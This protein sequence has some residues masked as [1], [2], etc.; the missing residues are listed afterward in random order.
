[1]RTVRA[2]Q[3]EPQAVGAAC[4]PLPAAPPATTRAVRADTGRANGPS[5]PSPTHG[6]RRARFYEGRSLHFVWLGRCAP[7]PGLHDK[8]GRSSAGSALP[9]QQRKQGRTRPVRTVRA[10][11]AEPQA[12]RAACAPRRG[13]N[14]RCAHSCGSSRPV[15]SA[16]GLSAGL[17]V[18]VPPAQHV[19]LPGAGHAAT[20]AERKRV[21]RHCSR[22]R[23]SGPVVSWYGICGRRQLAEKKKR[24]PPCPW[25]P[26]YAK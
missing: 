5:K 17:S 15:P 4:A 7:P 14:T 23:Q 6:S 1:M 3:A 21:E 11:K 9:R 8:I 12:V 13:G 19:V 18:L 22:G 24:L 16:A 25:M 2:A 10:A 20:P 26:S